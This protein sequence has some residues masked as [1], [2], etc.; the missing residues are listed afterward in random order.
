[1]NRKNLGYFVAGVLT[2]L[3]VRKCI[4]MWWENNKQINMEIANDLFSSESF[5]EQEF[6][7]S[8]S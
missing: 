5:L 6:G 8:V 1:M 2:A 7:S 3:I 4:D